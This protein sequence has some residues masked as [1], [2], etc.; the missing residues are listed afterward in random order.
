[1]AAANERGGGRVVALTVDIADA[2][3][4]TALPGRAA[5]A[6]GGHVEALVHNAGISRAAKIADVTLD[7]WNEVMRVNVTAAL[8]LVQAASPAMIEAGW[9]RI[10]NIGSIYSRLGAPHAGAY[11]ASKHALLGL[12]RVLAV[13]LVKHGVTANTIAPGFVDTEM[14]RAEAESVAAA[15]GIGVDDALARFLRVQ[16]LGRMVTAGEVGALAA[17]LC[18]DAAAPITGQCVN[19]DGGTHQG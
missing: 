6:L 13:E 2:G 17:F 5:E 3:A 18:S 15:R 9:G 10:V 11:T 4:C 7:D 8:L 12:T 19:I 16:P 14:V 1:M